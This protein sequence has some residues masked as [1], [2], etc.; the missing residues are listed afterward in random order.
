MYIVTAKTEAWGEDFPGSRVKWVIGQSR[1]VHDSLIERFRNDPAAWTVSG[2]SDA[3]PVQ[4][5]NNA[6]GG[7]EVSANG[8][9]A[10][11]QIG[12]QRKGR[13]FGGVYG[14]R[15]AIW[16]GGALQ[17][18][19][20]TAALVTTSD[21][22][23]RPDAA[24]KVLA[25]TQNAAQSFG[26]QVCE[27]ADYALAAKEGA[28]V[29]VKNTS[30]APLSCILTFFNPAAD[31]QLKANICV[32]PCDNWMFITISPTSMLS[33]GWVFGTDNIHFVRVAQNDALGSVWPTGATCYFGPVY[34]GVKGRA[35]FMLCNDDMTSTVYHPGSL[36]SGWPASGKSFREIVEYYGFKGTLY[37][38]PPKIGTAGYMTQRELL[39]MQDSGWAIGSHS[40]THPAY[41]SRGLTSLGPVG[42]ADAAD[43]Y[44]AQ[45]SNDDSAIYADI[46]AGID[47]C[48]RLGVWNPEYLFALPQGSWDAYVRSAAIRTGAKHIRA[49][50]SYNNYN[51]LGIGLPSGGGNS[52][53]SL[54]PGGWIHQGDA[55][56]TDGVLSDANIQAYV[57]ACIAQGATGANYHHAMTTANAA[58]LDV[59]VAYLKTKSDAGLIEVITA[60]QAAFD[61]GLI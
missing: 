14:T 22:P 12:K 58:Q 38:I 35:R 5:T 36:T 7:I 52:G 24:T 43:T 3:S 60:T 40:Y 55:V 50:S 25:L 26:Q 49:I 59:L 2:G 32:D 46:M 20:G 30:G 47:G 1:E 16:S 42:Y 53:S 27:T 39:E 8:R 9:N 18:S 48:R 11:Y 51:T 33:V 34:S 15:V 29:W 45:A 21:L 56:Q 31:H 28:G 19:A 37:C 10:N 23:Q 44:H 61:D 57:D 54:Q 6:T 13:T 17:N 41:S 4:A